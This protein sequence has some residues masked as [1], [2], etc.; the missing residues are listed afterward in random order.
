MADPLPRLDGD[1][2]L[3]LRVILAGP[4]QAIPAW[5]RL[6][7][8]F[9]LDRLGPGE[10]QVMPLLAARLMALDLG[11]PDLPRL[12]GIARQLSWR[13]HL[14][15]RDLAGGADALR[16]AGAPVL[17]LDGPA[18]SIAMY[19][20]VSRRPI[21]GAELVVPA[22]KFTVACRSLRRGGWRLS[23]GAA[24]RAR[25]RRPL[26]WTTRH[27]LQC[28]LRPSLPADLRREPGV[29]AAAVWAAAS[30]VAFGRARVEV[31]APVDVIHHLALPRKRSA[32]DRRLLWTVDVAHA[33]AHPA[34]DSAELGRRAA[35]SGPVRDALRVLLELD[36][37]AARPFG[38]H[39]Y[40]FGSA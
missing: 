18:L 11:H 6:R 39:D 25:A 31:P 38:T 33:L 9:S 27:G 7:P 24:L 30:P 22:E 36:V 23:G 13:A 12:R 4:D 21:T 19:G 32:A 37:D 14:A 16:R 26:R 8:R 34:L 17:A 29:D 1:P 10:F 35:L 40:A 15:A 28:T 2:Q 5:E 20:D 3:L